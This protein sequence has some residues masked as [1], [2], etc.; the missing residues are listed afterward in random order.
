MP[1]REQGTAGTIALLNAA[2]PPQATTAA[3]EFALEH[4]R[5]VNLLLFLSTLQAEM[6]E[7][8]LSLTQW[9]LGKAQQ[10]KF[11][12]EF[13]RE[14]DRRLGTPM[15][16]EA[17]LDLL[18]QI[19]FCRVVDNYSIYL[20]QLIT[21]IALARPEIM[22]GAEQLSAEF[23][24]S[25][26]SME[27]LQSALAQRLRRRLSYEGVAAT[28]KFL[29]QRGLTLAENPRELNRVTEHIELRNAI[30][31]GRGQVTASIRARLPECRGPV[32]RE[33]K[34]STA[35][36]SDGA[37]F[38]ARSAFRLDARAAR[39]F[40]LARRSFGTGRRPVR[41]KALLSN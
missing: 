6:K 22:K 25:F 14:H 12:K 16:L 23:V 30:V 18:N 2:F 39:K 29:S 33:I 10:S 8:D 4:I 19:T 5:V 34:I 32:G 36:L 35:R 21:L 20:E 41:G 1:R 3:I 38:L 9:I 26:M 31:H 28:A 27:D 17:H 7:L 15:T 11:H 37:V 24:L 40:G 13:L